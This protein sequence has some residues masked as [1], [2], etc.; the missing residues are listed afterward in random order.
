MARTDRILHSYSLQ[1]S[2]TVSTTNA[3]NS[4]NQQLNVAKLMSRTNSISTLDSSGLLSPSDDRRESVIH[5]PSFPTVGKQYYP[6]STS[7]LAGPGVPQGNPDLQDINCAAESSV[8]LILEEKKRWALDGQV[9]CGRIESWDLN[10]FDHQGLHKLNCLWDHCSV[11]P[12][13]C[14]D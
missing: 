3:P 14:R 6:G 8:R 10:T 2:K 1:A 9:G 7:V 12:L 11:G 4:N 13:P 5:Y